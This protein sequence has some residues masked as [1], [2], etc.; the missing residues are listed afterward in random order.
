MYHDTCAHM[1]ICTCYTH[2]THLRRQPQAIYFSLFTC[3]HTYIHI[4]VCDLDTQTYTCAQA[5]MNSRTLQV[6]TDAVIGV[7]IFSD[8]KRMA[9]CSYD[10]TVII[11]DVHSGQV[12]HTI[13]GHNAAVI[14]VGVSKDGTRLASGNVEGNIK[15]HELKNG[16]STELFTLKGHTCCVR[17]VKFSPD[18][19]K[20]ASCS[21][22]W[23][24]LLWSAQS[25]ERLL[26]FAFRGGHEY[27]AEWS[28]DSKLL[29][30][31][32]CE[33]IISVI[34]AATGTQVRELKGGL[35]F[36][37][38]IK[39]IVFGATSDVLYSGG[40]GDH[41]I[42]EWKLAEGQEATV[43]CTL[44]GHTRDVNSMSMSPCGMM[45]A[46]GSYDWTVVIWDLIRKSKIRVLENH[47]GMVES[48][49]WSGDGDIIA[50]GSADKT[51]RVWQVNVQV[52]GVSARVVFSSFWGFW[53]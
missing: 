17:S 27:C 49:A 40:D 18:D 21:A 37:I 15:V 7:D 31:A 34:D 29:A 23:K 11:S 42:R 41:A 24:L 8:S 36:W 14:C 35:T 12:M 16:S 44:R 20:I 4:P 3:I 26:T 25:G 39:C 10:G 46:S 6:H 52:R 22:D 51:V 19:Q 48:V 33:D 30:S 13:R 32:G 53:F 47:T 1:L 45:M 43:T 2:H 28:R 50:S 9:S 38:R 5:T